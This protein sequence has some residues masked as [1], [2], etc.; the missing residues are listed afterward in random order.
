ML[1][2]APADEEQVIAWAGLEL[3]IE[4]GMAESKLTTKIFA[5]EKEVYLFR[6]KRSFF[7]INARIIRYFTP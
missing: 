1:F 3:I 6:V 5:S 7:I 2:C 4:A